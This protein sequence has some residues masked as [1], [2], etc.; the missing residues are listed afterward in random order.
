MKHDSL[1]SNFIFQVLYQ[2]VI[3]LIPLVISPYL[4]RV[5]GSESLGIYT[6]T[7]SVA[8]YFILFANL[9]IAKHGQR[10]ISIRRNNPI[11]LRKTFWSLFSLHTLF[12]VLSII[13]YI[14]FCLF[15][16]GSDK[17][18][19]L[20]QTFYVASCAVDITWLFYG[21]ENFKS[22]VV[23]NIIFKIIECIL[24]FLFVKNSQDLWK[25][26]A[27]VSISVFLG[28]STILFQAI[29]IIKPIK[30]EYSF[31]LEHIKPLLLLF[32]SVIA[33][34]LYT[35]FDKTLLGLMSSA[36]NVA[37]YEYANKIIN[38]PKQIIYVIGTVLF[39]RSCK[40]YEEGN[41]SMQKKYIDI[42]MLATCFLGF[43]FTFGL[44]AVGEKFAIIYY[45]ETFK[46]S[47]VAIE[48]MSVL[49][50]IVMIGD[51]ARSEYLIPAH[52]DFI[53]T[54]SIVL[55]ALVNIILSIIMIKK[56]GLFGA[57]IGSIAAESLCTI[58]QL[59][60]CHK[61]YNLKHL[62]NKVIPYFIIGLIMFVV[63]RYIDIKTATSIKWLVIEI[64]IGALIY[65]VLSV[66][67]VL[68]FN[69]KEIKQIIKKDI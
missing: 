1:K 6:F 55:S 57:V 61:F 31:M 9:G 53:Y 49:I 65:I 32:I 51:I 23:K 63:V 10:I 5:L 46:T 17:M 34:T 54:F 60:S 12:S 41:F 4:T 22:V 20:I 37:Y 11:L 7:Y 21:L 43:A 19:Y 45:G 47:G 39:S 40:F 68:I 48:Y 25:Y 59:I 56:I 29:K 15:F 35:V 50:I 66:V 8:T 2:L 38:I 58:I 36:D 24:I 33:S 18:I 16:S 69:R 28:N 42:S 30:F 44:M 14:V 13:V 52:K 62:I 64:V 67:A 26:T 3:F 27:I